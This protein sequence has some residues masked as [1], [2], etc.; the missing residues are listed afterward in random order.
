MSSRSALVLIYD[1]RGFTAA[2]RR[3]RT[4]DLGTF[5]TGA[6]RT[7]LDLF[8]SV[9]P[10]FVKN[11]G[12]G[13]LL[14]WESESTTPDPELVAKVVVGANLARTA[15]TAFVAGSDATGG[16]LPKAVGVGVA[17]GE[18]SRQDDYY[19][20]ALN[21][22]A[23]LQNLAR[24]EGL[25]LDRNV[26]ETASARDATVRQ[27]F[28]KSRV[29][30]KGL[31]A[32]TVWVQRPF[33][34]ARLLGRA[35]RVA[36]ILLVPIAYVLLADAGLGLPG[37]KAIRSWFDAREASFF[38]RPGLD[39]EVRAGAEDLRRGF[40]GTLLA[41]R[42]APGWI[43]SDLRAKEDGSLDVWSS[44][45]AIAA[46]F[47]TPHLDAQDLRPFLAGLEATFAPDIL[48]EKDGK[49]LGWPAHPG[50]PYVEIEPAL[51]TVA[52]VARALGRPGLVAAADRERFLGLLAKAQAIADRHY[53][54]ED[55]GWNIFPNQV[56]PAVHSPYSTALALLALLD[57]RAG[58]LPWSGS[59]ER[60]DA[61]L[62]AT[63]ARVVSTFVEDR[64][65]GWRRTHDRI[66]VISPGLTL[67]S[68]A[69]LL[70]AE[71]E[72]GIPVPPKIL[73]AATVHL[74][75][76]E[77]ASMEQPPDAGEFSH[78]VTGDDGKKMTQGES[79]NF[80]WHPWAI[81]AASRWLARAERHP[82]VASDR[83]RIRRVLGH[84]VLGLGDDAVLQSKDT[85]TFVS[86]ESLIGLSAVPPPAKSP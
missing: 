24:P 63:V 57:V 66:D 51:W 47:G 33:S 52:A 13:H 67:Q 86:S 17:F 40:A 83:Y 78:F 23:R 59:T 53:K 49:T 72:A 75:S 80:L 31:G 74:A 26:F 44:S 39:E 82:V 18:V 81:D 79:I 11:L 50:Y 55:G 6:H 60:R 28:T 5:M 1:I 73:D 14:L 4:A 65:S 38:R 54:T 34:W 56:D 61:L 69:L 70:R 10:T 8:A 25:A 29:R 30:L 16:H 84:L 64:V 46:L 12:D 3:M 36:A 77:G 22:A 76:L 68:Y 27:A 32:T 9:P 2:S 19:G 48:L 41:V 43:R 37:G 45:Q 21:L 58:G 85:W 20:V 15:F 7:I 42:A 35:A 62:A 71:A